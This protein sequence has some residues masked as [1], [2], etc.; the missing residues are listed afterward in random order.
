MLLDFCYAT[1][2][3]FHNKCNQISLHYKIPLHYLNSTAL[4]EFHHAIELD[5]VIRIPLPNIA[6]FSHIMRCNGTPL[7]NWNSI[8]GYNGIPLH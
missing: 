2:F 7:N 1:Y 8:K 3:Q 5:N 4:P 6:E